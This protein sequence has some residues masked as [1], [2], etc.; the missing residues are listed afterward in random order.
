ML[1]LA[2]ASS[3]PKAAEKAARLYFE[4]LGDIFVATE[5]KNNAAVTKYYEKS[6]TDLAAFK[7][8]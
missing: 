1:R 7:A 8:F 3:D 2:A 6:V 5:Q 4:D